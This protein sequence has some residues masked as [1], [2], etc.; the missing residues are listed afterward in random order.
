MVDQAKILIR[1]G[2]GGN[3]AVSFRREKFIPKGGPDGGDGGKGGSVYLETDPNQNTLDSFAHQQKFEAGDGRNG[4]GKKMAGAKGGDLVI[5]VPLG[6]IVTLK[7]F[8]PKNVET[9]DISVRGMAK[10]RMGRLITKE[11]PEI[12]STPQIIDFDKPGISLLIA[13]GGNG[14]RGNVHFK[15]SHNTTPMSAEQGQIGQS[16]EAE[17]SLKL[18]AD[19]GLVGLPNAGKSTLLSVLSN[20]RPKVADYEFTTLE[21]NLGVLKTHDRN[22]VIADI[23]GLIEGASEGKGLG[24]RF[25]KHIERTKLLVHLV[26]VGEEPK[27][28]FDKYKKIRKEL[29]EYGEEI[30]KKEEIVVLSKIDLI[31][32]EE[33]KEIQRY[34]KKKKIEILPI[35]SATQKGVTEL[36]ARMQ[37]IR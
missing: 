32:E 31:G 26:P 30:G 35:S 20:A 1:A 13:K 23:P 22:L 18:L 29:V 25:L 3:G 7:P 21:P 28:I 37:R 24:T 33:V 16:F 17:L 12:V 19:V 6:T 34:F 11:V 14:G 15:G 10:G 36:I 2:K 4:T 9:V 5:K 8:M 27:D